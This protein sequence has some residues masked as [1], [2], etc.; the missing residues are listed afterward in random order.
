[1]QRDTAVPARAIVGTLADS[2]VMVHV[3][4]DQLYD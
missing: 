1:V 3:T 2:A 4:A